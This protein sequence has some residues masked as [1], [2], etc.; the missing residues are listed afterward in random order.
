[1]ADKIYKPKKE[2]IKTQKTGT[3][4]VTSG[5][6]KKKSYTDYSKEDFIAEIE[7]LKKRK[8]YG[9]VWEEQEEKF[10]KDTIGKLPV[11]KEVKNREIKTDKNSPV[12]LLIEG[13]NYHSLSVLNYTHEKSVDVIYIDPP[14]NTG[15]RDFIYNDSYVDREDAY[16]HSKWLSFMAKR[17]KLAKN[18][19]KGKGIIFIS[20][21]DNE[22]P[23]L[24]LLLDD[25]FGEQNFL[26]NIKLKVKAA[27][28]VGQ[29][30]FLFDI[31][32][33]VLVY[34]KDASLVTN[35]KPQIEEPITSDTTS[36][37]NKILKSF[38]SEKEIKK[39]SGGIV[40]EI[41]VYQHNDFEIETIPSLKRDMPTYYRNFEKIFR[42]T[43]PQGGLM[44]R[45]MPQLPK[46]GLVSIEYIP[47]KGRSKGERFRYYFFNGSLLVW[48]KDTAL[49]D[50]ETKEV[51]KLV[52]NSNLW[53]ENMH[54]G[55][56][57]EGDIDFHNGKKPVKLIKK[58]IELH[59]N[60]KNA[61]ILDFFA[62]SGTTGE[63][64]LEMNKNDGGN[65]QFILG[66][67]NENN[68]AT[69]IC[70]PRL[71]NV[72][73]G[74]KKRPVLG[75]NLKY[76]KTA[77]VDATPTDDNKKKLTAQSTEILC[78]RENTFEQVLDKKDFKIFRNSKQHTG[79]VFDQAA[80]A[81][82][83]REAKK[84]KGSIHTYIFSLEDE[85]FAPEFADMDGRIIV[86]PIP[87]A[88]LRVY[89]RIF[90]IKI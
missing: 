63:A 32:E 44:K 62:G 13:D 71:K 7:Q 15:N 9:I 65:R 60:H 61:V 74:Y 41:K 72:I 11:L 55:I 8:K 86:S 64:V 80:I 34:A 52:K 53:L 40:G 27:A 51:K 69:D 16:R 82:F 30:S 68:I 81:D 25:I 76:F 17:L 46:K 49:K 59:P 84:I 57:G 66:T 18:V 2:E 83:K 5:N 22:M 89:R 1:M 45:V 3:Y 10:D 35:N 23:Q 21:D 50:E 33:Y 87:E 77:F 20:I 48:L 56:A 37:Y 28:G 26:S 58:L 47:S 79:I 38:G 43:N 36:T 90:S 42:T 14:Y 12:N 39:I 78:V 67:N 31:C 75:G 6:D 24:K 73:R 70:H 88:I 4:F 19:L 54:Q 29:E 85:D